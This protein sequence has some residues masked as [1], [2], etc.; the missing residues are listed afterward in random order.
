M[1]AYSIDLRERVLKDWDRGL[2]ADDVAEKYSV[3]AAPGSTAW[4][5]GAEKRAK[6]ARGSKRASARWRWRGKRIGC[7]PSSPRGPIRRWPS[8]GRRCRRR[9][10][11]PRSGAR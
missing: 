10:A 1:A 3:S 4:C 5:S 11:S 2:K 8:C 6:S 7:G 9:R